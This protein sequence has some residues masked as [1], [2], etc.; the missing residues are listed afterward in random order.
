MTTLKDKKKITPQEAL[1]RLEALC[2][3]SEQCTSD[4]RHKLYK[5]EISQSD[6]DIIINKLSKTRFVDDSR[7]AV[8]YCRDKYRFNRWGRIKIICG[9]RAK[10]IS[11]H[12]IQEALKTID[13]KEYE[14]ILVSVVKSKALSIK[15][16]DTFE[17]RTRLFRAVASRGY[18][19]AL[20]AKIIKDQSL[21]T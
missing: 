7:F 12:D 19:S 4:L 13:N 20:I 3:Q 1:V 16:V 14:D 2:A 18:E 9:L 6:S 11:S 17:G 15:D 5:W 10:Q 8:A 21:W